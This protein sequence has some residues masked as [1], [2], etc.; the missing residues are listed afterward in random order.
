[1]SYAAVM[2]AQGSSVM[3]TNTPKGTRAVPLIYGGCEFGRRRMKIWQLERACKLFNCD[4][5]NVQ[6]NSGSQQTQGVFTALLA[7]RHTI[8]GMSLDGWRST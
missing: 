7:T 4:F 5:A 8:L 6:P 1:M 2:A 3:T